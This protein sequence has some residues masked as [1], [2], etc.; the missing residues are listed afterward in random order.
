M[1]TQV[2]DCVRPPNDEENDDDGDDADDD[3]GD[4][5]DDGGD[6]DDDD[7]DDGS[8]MIMTLPFGQGATTSGKRPSN[9]AITR[10]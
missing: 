9:T 3:G 8:A 10:I 5:D 4:D 7:A 1:G 2:V 6:D